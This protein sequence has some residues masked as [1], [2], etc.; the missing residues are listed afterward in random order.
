MLPL[1]FKNQHIMGKQNQTYVKMS[2]ASQLMPQEELLMQKH[3]SKKFTIGVPKEIV[4]QEKRVALVPSAASLLV[5]NG[6]RV[7]VE[8]DAGLNANFENKLYVDG[9]VELVDTAGEIYQCDIVLK[10]APPTIAEIVL[11]KDRL[12]LISAIHERIQ[13]KAYYKALMNK[14]ITALSYEHIRNDSDEHPVLHSIS[15]IVGATSI[16][17]ASQYLCQPDWGRGKML[18]G[19]TGINPS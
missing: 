5:E 15:E 4:F 18:G 19:F 17:I 10:V 12:I 2:G 13:E 11:M 3:D 16:L 1:V 8:K 6:H 9:G 7:I 14:R